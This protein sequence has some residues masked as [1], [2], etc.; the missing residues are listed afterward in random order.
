MFVTYF[1]EFIL[2]I[3]IAP[4]GVAK[5]AYRQYKNK[6]KLV[7]S[8]EKQLVIAAIFIFVF[9]ILITDSENVFN[10]LTYLYGSSGILAIVLGILMILK[11]KK[12][13]KY[14]SA[15]NN[16]NLYSINEIAKFMSLPKETVTKDLLD[17][18]EGG[19]LPDLKYN[20][21]TKKLELNA[22]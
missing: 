4:A 16:H 22:F 20:R 3:F 6:E 14:K 9:I 19:L 8:G 10:P 2:C 15:I 5:I 1:W 12:Y 17:M 7:K 21:E 13:N 11:G 18:I